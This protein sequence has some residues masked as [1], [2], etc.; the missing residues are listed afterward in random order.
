MVTRGVCAVSVI[1]GTMGHLSRC[2]ASYGGSSSRLHGE[3]RVHLNVLWYTAEGRPVGAEHLAGTVG[4]GFA[5]HG[6]TRGWGE[7]WGLGD[8][9]LAAGLVE[10]D[11]LAWA[12]G[13]QLE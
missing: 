9:E 6:G 1:R 4:P 3:G 11:K 12:R 2:D 8:D 10:V 7:Q 13:R 5:G